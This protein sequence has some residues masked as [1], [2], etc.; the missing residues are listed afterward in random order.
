MHSNSSTHSHLSHTYVHTNALNSHRNSQTPI[1][2]NTTHMINQI[3]DAHMHAHTH[4][5]TDTS[6]THISL[7]HSRYSHTLTHTHSHSHVVT[8]N[9]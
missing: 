8:T 2:S 6:L 4:T 1:Q 9:R 3:Q 7:T 5:L